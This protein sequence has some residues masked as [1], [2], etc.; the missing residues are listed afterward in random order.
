M[1]GSFKKVRNTYLHMV[2]S[3]YISGQPPK[4]TRVDSPTISFIEEDAR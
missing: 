1:A 2:Q 4:A 3:V